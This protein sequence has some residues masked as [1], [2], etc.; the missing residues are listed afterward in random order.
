MPRFDRYLLSQYV[1]VFGISSLIL[2]LVYWINQ[3]VRLFDQ[4]IA[5]GESA[6]VFFEFTALSLPAVMQIVL[7]LAA[8]VASLFVTN[9]LI[10]E[11]ELVVVQATGYS[12][13]RLARPIALFGL[14]VMLMMA[15]LMHWLVPASSRGLATRSAEISQNISARLLTEGRFVSPAPG[16]T[17]YIREI[18]PDGE[19]LDIFLSDSRAEDQNTI[20]TAGRAFLVRGEDETTNLVMLNGMVQ[21]LSEEDRSLF[22]TRFREFAYD[23]AGLLPTEATNARTASQVPTLDL[24]FPTAA[25]IDETGQSRAVLIAEAHNR[26]VQALMAFIAAL[27][28]FSSLLT[29]RYS[30]FGVWPQIGN[31]IG[32]VVLIKLAETTG[33]QLARQNHVLWPAAYFPIGLGSL[34]ISFQLVRLTYPNWFRRRRR[35]LAT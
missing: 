33:G 25:L 34:I 35:R 10:N 9:R 12:P 11:S 18:T 21:Y 32:F 2:I 28:G 15:V 1:A 7:P 27:L 29:V 5:N 8:F 19:L 14:L 23:L 4:L 26:N 13:F 22:T 16:I 31:A 3:A 30:R 20:Y 17:F 24:L 6:G